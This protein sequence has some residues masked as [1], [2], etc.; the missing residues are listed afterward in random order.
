M[1]HSF[2]FR[3][4]N[5]M[6]KSSMQRPRIITR[7]LQRGGGAPN[8]KQPNTAMKELRFSSRCLETL[9]FNAWPLVKSRESSSLLAVMRRPSFGGQV[10]GLL[11]L[12]KSLSG[13]RGTQKLLPA[14]LLTHTHTHTIDSQRHRCLQQ[15]L[16]CD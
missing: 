6:W 11:S 1:S 8:L 12:G 5:N 13:R 16:R 4:K 2:Q 3:Q 9:F 7:Y 10:L 15:R 14:Q